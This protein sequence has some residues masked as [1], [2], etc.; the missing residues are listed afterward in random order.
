VARPLPLPPETPPGFPDWESLMRVA[1]RAAREAVALEEVPVGAAIVAADGALLATACNAPVTSNDPTGHAEIR[2][3][4]AA[5]IKARNYRLPGAIMAVTLEPCMMCAGALVQARLAGVVFGAPDPKSGALLSQIELPT[6][7]FLNHQYWI[8]GNVLQQECSSLL[9][10]FFQQ[11][12]T[13]ASNEES[14]RNFTDE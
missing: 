3:L 11:R 14:S 5:A 1:L 10:D 4:R 9:R 6:L 8:I 12:R 7:R 2:C 13:A